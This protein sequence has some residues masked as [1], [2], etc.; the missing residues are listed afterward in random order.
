MKPLV[1]PVCIENINEISYYG[2]MKACPALIS[3]LLLEMGTVESGHFL[4]LL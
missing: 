4:F 3:C 2:H 1:V